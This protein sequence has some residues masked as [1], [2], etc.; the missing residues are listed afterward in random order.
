MIKRILHHDAAKQA[1]VDH[2]RT[3]IIQ[4]W[5]ET[6]DER[7]PLACV[8]FALPGNPGI[9]GGPLTR[10]TSPIQRSLPSPLSVRR[11]AICT[12]FTFLLHHLS[13]WPTL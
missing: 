10:T 3:E 12:P 11:Q 5:V 6:A 8:W 4:C 9:N 2:P 13:N 1:R 7:C